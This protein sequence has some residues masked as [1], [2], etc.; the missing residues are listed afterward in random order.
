MVLPL[1][2]LAIL[3]PHVDFLGRSSLRGGYGALGDSGQSEVGDPL[4]SDGVWAAWP[5]GFATAPGAYA[6]AVALASALLGGSRSP[7]PGARRRGRGLALAAYVLTSPLLVVANW[8]RSLVLA[9]PF[10]DVYLHNPGRLRYVAVLAIPILAAAGLQGLDRAAAVVA[11]RGRVDRDRGNPARR[12]AAAGRGRARAVRD[13]GRRARRRGAAPLR[14][15]DPSVAMGDRTG[16]RR[17]RRGRAGGERDL[18]AGLRR[19][20]DLHRPRDRGSSEPRAAGAPVPRAGRAGVPPPRRSS[21]T[22]APS[23]VG[24]PR[25]RLPA[26]AFEKG[27][28]W[29]KSPDDW[30]ALAPSRGTL[31]EVPTPSATTPSSSLVTGGTSGPR[32]TCRS[33]TTH[34]CSTCPRRRT[35]ASWGSVP[36]GPDRIAPPVDGRVVEEADGYS[37]WELADAQSLATLTDQAD[38]VRSGCRARRGHDRRLRS[39]RAG[40]DR[41]TGRLHVRRG[42]PGADRSHRDMGVGFGAAGSNYLHSTVGS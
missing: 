31:F 18:R 22:S 3:V 40:R 33:S 41:T 5:L 34:R 42:M 14:P 17:G 19:R 12:L 29:M 35:C 28:L 39:G 4:G 30:P 8:F 36:R 21:R 6:G 38:P 16:P 11:S 23:R 26:A 20:H 9:L 25:G 27:Y 24:T 7:A 37:L 1:A 10:G 15:R 13:G 2:S 32:T